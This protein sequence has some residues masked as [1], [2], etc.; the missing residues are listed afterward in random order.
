MA[1]KNK[2]VLESTGANLLYFQTLAETRGSLSGVRGL[3]ILNLFFLGIFNFILGPVGVIEL[4]SESNIPVCIYNINVAFMYACAVFLVLSVFKR[5]IYRFQVFFSSVVAGLAALMV[6]LVCFMFTALSAKAKIGVN[7]TALLVFGLLGIG[8]LAAAGVAHWRLLQRRLSVGHSVKRALG[9]YE[10]VSNVMASKRFW[11]IFVL[12][13]I[14]PNILTLGQYVLNTFGALSLVFLAAVMT[15][16]PVELTYLAY[17]KSKDRAYWQE[18]PAP[19]P[20]EDRRRIIKAFAKW[21][22]ILGGGFGVIWVMGKFFPIWF[23]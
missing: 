6:V 18:A 3:A 13:T 21:I 8:V 20:L 4:Y 5:T 12:V 7:P 22:L 14:V 23:G 10:T 15:S 17:L 19:M 16:L 9:N 11:I 2:K 1:K